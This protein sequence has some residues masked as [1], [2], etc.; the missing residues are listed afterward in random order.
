MKKLLN[1]LLALTIVA[2][3]AFAAASQQGG[4]GPSY[5][6][7]PVT[8]IVPYAPGGGSDTLVR[9]VMKSIK[10]P[11]N[12][13]MVAVN[14]EGA[15]GF[16]GGMRAYNSPADGYTIMTH[17]T[18]DLLSY[19]QS[20]QDT[21]PIITE[22]TTI[23][24][25]V[26][27]Y[28]VISTNKI[29][30][31]EYGWKSIEDVV[32]WCKANPGKKLRWGTTG[33]QNDNW[34]SSQRVARE[35]GIFDSFTFTP[36]DSGAAT[37]TASLQ[38]EVEVSM[39]T[40][41]EVPGVVASGDNIPLLVV[42]STRIKSLPNT[43]TTQEKGIKVTTTKPRGFF[44]PKGMNSEHVKVLSDALKTVC[45]DP[46][47]Q[48][49]IVKL[50]FDVVFMDSATAKQKTNEWLAELQPFYDEFKKNR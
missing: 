16:T 41:S 24:L 42:N 47:F 38:N 6:T 18:L 44:G 4:S 19:F 5:P 27:D 29:A 10:L 20:G 25:V 26:T 8:C 3:A 46:E 35:L 32:A 13:S 15:A 49:T 9:A 40:A 21:V 30:A 43:P 39:N 1:L 50:G 14:V 2:S 31:A 11:N 36:Y 22:G 12:Q 23:A 28:N 48:D 45:D 7:K 17:N 34:I 37:R 33:A